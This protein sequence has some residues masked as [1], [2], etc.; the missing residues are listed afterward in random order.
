L[1]EAIFIPEGANPPPKS[2]INSEELQ[3]YIRD[4]GMFSDDNCLVAE[5]DGKIV[6]AVWSRIMNDYGHVGDGIPSLAISLYKEFRNKGIGTELLSQMLQLLRHEGYANVSLSVQKANYA[7]N[8]YIKTGFA[9]VKE[10]EE[11]YIMVCELG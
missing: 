6:G 11:E 9:V 10:T 7:T 1:Y 4:F 3:I 2:I 8:M 5:T